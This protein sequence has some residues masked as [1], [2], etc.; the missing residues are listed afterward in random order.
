MPN[1]DEACFSA[2]VRACP[3]QEGIE[4]YWTWPLRRCRLAVFRFRTWTGSPEK[5]ERPGANTTARGAG[6]GRSMLGPFVCARYRLV[7]VP[8]TSIRLNAFAGAT[9]RGGFGHVFKRTVC[10]WPPGECAKCLLKHTCSYPYIFETAPPPGAEKLRGLEQIPRPFVIEPPAA[11]GRTYAAGERFEFGLVLVGRGIDYLPYFVLTFQQLGQ[12][13]LGADKGQYEVAEVHAE[14]VG[15]WERIYEAGGALATAGRPVR[16]ADLAEAAGGFG[17]RRLRIRFLTPARIRSDGAIRSRL[18][19]QDLIRAL[20]RRLSSLCYFHCGGELPVDFKGLIERAAE[21]R[22]VESSLCW[23]Q[24]ERFS[25]RQYRR[26]EM[27]GVEGTV[28]FESADAETWKPYLPLLL[29]G[30]W[31]H[32]GKGA[33]MGL[34]RMRVEGVS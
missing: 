29:A 8:Q 1:V 4:K 10:V 3:D 27:G 15:G 21:V 18:T 24:L 6:E 28:T 22:T 26:I 31:V 19:F 14:G 2:G 5:P 16:A 32:V 9:L 17:S 23:H 7:A 33:V 20:L 13:G 12:A 30:E 25:G 11:A 34:G